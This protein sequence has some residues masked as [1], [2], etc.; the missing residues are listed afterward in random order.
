MS[1]KQNKNEYKEKV[2]INDY[3]ALLPELTEKANE[4][5]K[6]FKKVME[7]LPMDLKMLALE[8]AYLKLHISKGMQLF[9]QER[10]LKKEVENWRKA[11]EKHQVK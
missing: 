5:L 3:D 8:K 9:I 1:D 7:G 6:D 10:R 4:D 11:A 2:S